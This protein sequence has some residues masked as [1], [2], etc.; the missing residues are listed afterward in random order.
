MRNLLI[1]VTRNPLSLV[2][3]TLTTASALLIISLF[4]LEFFGL[5]GG[6]YMGILSFLVLPA[7]FLLGLLLIPIGLVRERRRRERA[8][9]RGEVQAAFPIVDFNRPRTRNLAVGF[10][11][12]TCINLVIL[13]TATY[14][15]VQVMESQ[16]FCGQACHTVMQPEYTAYLNGPHAHVACVECHIGP[17]ASWFV[18]SKLSGS[19]QLIA[20]TFNLYP[21]P[22]GTPVTNLRPARETCEHCHW[23]TRFVGDRLRV[24]TKYA[25]DE[26][27]SATKSVL[28]MR[29]GGREGAT[30]HGIHWHVDP[31]VRIR[32]RADAKRQK[33]G[34]V[35]LTLKDGTVKVFKSAKIKESE[36]SLEWRTMDCVD[37]HNRP[38]HTFKLPEQEIDQ[39]IFDGRIDRSLPFVRREGLAAMKAS[40]ASAPVA[41]AGITSRLAAFYRQSYP[42]IATAKADAIVKASQTLADLWGKNVFPAMKV[43]W[44]TY[45]NNIGHDP[46][47]GCFRCHD[48]EHATAKGETITQDCS[49]CHSLLAVDDKDPAV[50]KQLQP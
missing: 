42:Q 49:T 9:A 6:P 18:K 32:Y 23:P 30:A 3:A 44:G 34:D 17:G 26:T 21:T 2:G 45:P 50:L 43:S 14:K 46:F 13:T 37:C 48:E 31:G 29:V 11:G 4:S 16:Q 12:L 5:R 38:S 7:I 22:I 36:L 19:W 15:G 8:A 28:M 20:V 1:A 27:S 40:Y 35:E 24:V 47:P 33:I 25:S 10:F 41:T 39:A